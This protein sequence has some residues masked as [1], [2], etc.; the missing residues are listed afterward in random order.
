VAYDIE[1]TGEYSRLAKITVPAEE[2]FEKSDAAL[3]EL[4]KDVDIEGFREGKVP[5]KIMRKRFGDRVAPQIVEE[6]VET[7]LREVLMDD[8]GEVL[9][10]GEPNVTNVPSQGGGD[11]EFEIDYEVRPEVEIGDYKNLEIEKPKVEVDREEVDEQLEQLQEQYA[12]LEPIELRDT[13]KEGDV[14]TI[15]YR[16]TVDEGPAA[17]I[18]DEDVQVEVGSEGLLPGINDALVGADFHTTVTAEID[19]DDEFPVEELQ[20]DTFEL[21][22]DIKSVKRRNLPELDD[23]FAKDTGEAETLLELRGQIQSEIED[24]KEEEA[25]QYAM[26]EIVDALLEDNDFELPEGFVQQQVESEVERRKN[27]MQ[28]MMQRSGQQMPDDA[29]GE[30]AMGEIEEDVRRQ[31]KQSFLFSAIADREDIDVGEDDIQEHVQ[32]YAEQNQMPVQQLMEHLKQNQEQ[33]QQIKS[34]ILTDKVR[35]LLIENAETEQI[36]WPEDEKPTPHGHHH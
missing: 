20:G 2:Y 35:D 11:L 10:I 30:E 13:V 26:D 1:E 31:L 5:M 3:K 21:E 22:V 29:F 28:Q 15:D 27:Y 36:E 8:D 18:E 34:E 9:Y 24:Q 6:L 16:S 19:A 14:V 12:T 25:R 33:I 17:E 7:K 23:E 4:S 32:Q